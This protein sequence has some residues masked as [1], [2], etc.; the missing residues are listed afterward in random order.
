MKRKTIIYIGLVIASYYFLSV[1]FT[2]NGQFIQYYHSNSNSK[3]ESK[4]KGIFITDNLKIS[5]LKDSAS[6]IKNSFDIWIDNKEVTRKYGILP[7][8]CITSLDKSYRSFNINFKENLDENLKD[9]IMLKINNG[10]FMGNYTITT[11]YVNPKDVVIV[12][13]Y[14][15]DKKTSFGQIKVDVGSVPN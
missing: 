12:D 2:K 11:Q 14:I 1:C 13:F 8:I 6:I 7:F 4:E 15:R 3:K 10:D 9:N 5:I